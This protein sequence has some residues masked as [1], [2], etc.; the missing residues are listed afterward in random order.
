MRCCAANA[1]RGCVCRSSTLAARGEATARRPGRGAVGDRRARARRRRTQ[2]LFDRAARLRRELAGELGGAAVR[3]VQRCDAG[4]AGA[5]AARLRRSAMLDVRG[6]GPEASSRRSGRASSP[7][8]ARTAVSRRSAATDRGIVPRP[9]PSCPTAIAMSQLPPPRS[10]STPKLVLALLASGAAALPAQEGVPAPPGLVPEQMWPAPTAADWQKPCCDPRGSA[11]GT[12]PC[13]LSQDDAAADPRLRQHGRRD[14][15]RALRRRAL[16]RSRDRQ[17]LRAVRLRDRVGLPPQP[18]RPRRAGPPHPVP[19]LRQRTCGEHIAM[20]PIV[21]AKF[22]D[23]KRIAPRHI[24]V[25]LDGKRALRRVLH[26][27]HAVGVRRIRDGIQNRDVAGRADRARRSFAAARRCRAA[28]SVDRRPIE[29]AFAP[30]TPGSA[31]ALLEAALAMGE[32]APLELLRLAPTGFDPELA[33]HGARRSR[34]G[35]APGTAELDRRTLQ[36]RRCR[37]PNANR[38][39]QA[40]D[41]LARRSPLRAGAGD[42]APRPLERQAGADR[43][44]D[45]DERARGRIA[46]TR[47]A[48]IDIELGAAA[49]LRRGRRS[50][51]CGP[52]GSDP[53]RQLERRRGEPA[54]RSRWRRA[55][56]SPRPTR[57]RP[58]TPRG[59]AARGRAPAPPRPPQRGGAPAWRV[60][61]A[62]RVA[63]A[64]RFG[65]CATLRVCAVRSRRRRHAGT[66]RRAAA[67]RR[68]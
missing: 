59:P 4:S 36:A 35:G 48:P 25:E 3:G 2:A 39:S 37:P 9:L 30:A 51:V 68:C 40:L 1:G 53:S 24:M 66:T 6:I 21:F 52:I 18:A 60:A 55:T 13:A 46:P 32:Q 33:R 61:G 47:A 38:W 58:R 23:G 65:D 5:P 50:H 41:R 11:P 49:Q 62:A 67:R 31:H 43:P 20:E 19:A 54:A 34:Q 64:T 42:R 22:L 7:R 29:Q 26:V 17:A 44:A 14:R 12:T 16:P 27:G 56:S 28:D 45:L 15:E 8:S 63:A 57:G 10:V